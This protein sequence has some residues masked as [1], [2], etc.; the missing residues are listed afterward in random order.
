MPTWTLHGFIFMTKSVWIY[1][2][3]LKSFPRI[4]ALYHQKVL[5][6]STKFHREQYGKHANRCIRWIC[7][8]LL[9]C[10]MY[11]FTQ[12]DHFKRGQP[13]FGQTA[14]A[15]LA[16]FLFFYTTNNSCIWLNETGLPNKPQ[17]QSLIYI[18][19]VFQHAGLSCQ[20]KT[21]S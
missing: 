4:C 1:Q 12:S 10:C 6:R 8:L 13:W 14:C 16:N 9:A 19:V 18:K 3:H 21:S 11:S 5:T 2:M 17:A 20:A 7:A 15:L